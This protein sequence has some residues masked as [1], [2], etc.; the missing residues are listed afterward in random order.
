MTRRT[1]TLIGLGLVVLYLLAI[2]DHWAVRPDSGLYLG[3]GRSL[4]EGRGMAFNGGQW[5]GIPPVVP[6]LVAGC[7]VLVGEHLWLINAVM[8][9]F[10]LGVVLLAYLTATRL[11][12][13]LPESVR[14]GLAPA[15]L[16][17]VGTSGR[18]FIDSTRVLTDVPFTFFVMLGLYA[19]VRARDGHWAWVAAGAVALLAAT[20]TR[21]VGPVFVV[22]MGAALV[23]DAARRGDRTRRVAAALGGMAV[24]AVGFGLWVVCVRSRAEAGTIDYLEPRH[25][26]LFNLLAPSKWREVCDGLLALPAAVTSTIVYQKLPWVNLVPAGLMAVG[27]WVAARRRQ[28]LVVLPILVYVAFLLALGGATASRYLLP[29]MPLLAYA[30]LV[31]VQTVAAWLRKR[32]PPGPGAAPDRRRL[33]LAVAVGLCA[34]VSL[35]RVGRTVYWA[36]HPQFD[37][38]LEHGKWQGLL[39]A[40]RYVGERGRPGRDRV[41]AHD[42]YI[43]HYVSRLETVTQISW[44]GKPA[45]HQTDVPPGAFAEV[46]VAGG[47]RFVIVPTD[48][49]GWSGAAA[50]AL[51]ATGRFA[52]PPHTIA[53]LAVY[54][55]L[56]A[57]PP[58]AQA[59]N[60]GTP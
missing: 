28:W 6:L 18:L 10:G 58:S 45:E 52:D 49:D 40:S 27:L 33:A 15:V 38:V 48:R 54:E 39:D 8:S 24:V 34:A 9:L 2:N 22:A 43:V 47:Y 46:A 1:L 60:G 32:R 17:V 25:L 56:V 41:L 11:S 3:L 31:G 53:D 44:Q 59:T 29:V 55:R 14:A 19:W 7:H 36:R 35:A 13:D 37:E 5:W 50:D 4:A 21:I 51:R 16:L 42:L 30:L 57:G 20:M 23:L 12:A 26:A